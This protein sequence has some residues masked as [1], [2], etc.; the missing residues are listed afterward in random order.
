MRGAAAALLLRASVLLQPPSR[1]GRVACSSYEREQLYHSHL[2]S[3]DLK[4]EAGRQAVCNGGQRIGTLLVYLNDVPSGGCTYFNVLD[5]R[6]RPRGGR[7][8]LF[9]PCF[10]D[11]S[12]DERMLHTAERAVDTK[13]IAQ[14]WIRQSDFFGTP[15]ALPVRSPLL[16]LA[17]VSAIAALTLPR[18]QSA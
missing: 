9:F 10:A 3:F 13:H 6:V 7:A 4:T 18:V 2:D 5:L 15:S 12:V 1:C 17:P 16:S 11:G 8:L 14:L